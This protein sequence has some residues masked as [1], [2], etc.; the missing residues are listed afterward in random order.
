MR[1]SCTAWKSERDRERKREGAE[2]RKKD[3]INRRNTGLFFVVT[4]PPSYENYIAD[5]S[6][7]L[8]CRHT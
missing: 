3:A 7:R 8:T 1:R 4:L 2:E 6:T 5:Q